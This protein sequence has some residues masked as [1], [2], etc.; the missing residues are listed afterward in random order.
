M[1]SYVVAIEF[2]LIKTTDLVFLK[3][4]GLWVH[5]AMNL[6]CKI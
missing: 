2:H 5:R 1:I 3:F 6:R 4:V